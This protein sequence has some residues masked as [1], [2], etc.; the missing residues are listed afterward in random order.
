MGGGSRGALETSG[1]TPVIVLHGGPGHG[2]MSFKGSIDRLS[3]GRRPVLFYDQRGSG[4]SE[5]KGDEKVRVSLLIEDI[6]NLRQQMLN[7]AGKVILFGHSAGGAV[8]QQY[9]AKHP[10]RVLKMILVGRQ[11]AVLVILNNPCN[12]GRGP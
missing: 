3:A 1:L 11:S 2:M 9:A 7:D 12:C 10:D 8:A 6:E 4:H 5:M